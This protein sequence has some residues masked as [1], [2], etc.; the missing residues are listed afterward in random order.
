MPSLL[1]FLNAGEIITNSFC[2]LW[3]IELDGGKQGFVYSREWSLMTK[4]KR[5]PRYSAALRH[6]IMR[7]KKISK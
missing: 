6:R 1:L 2:G 4:R 5:S 7:C 3:Q